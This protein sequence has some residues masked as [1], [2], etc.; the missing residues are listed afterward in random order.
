MCR[1]H[2]I[3]F[4]KKESLVLN[5]YKNTIS[6]SYSKL[7]KV[8]RMAL[9]CSLQKNWYFSQEISNFHSFLLKRYQ[10]CCMEQYLC[11]EIIFPYDYI[12]KIIGTWGIKKWFDLHN[13]SYSLHYLENIANNIKKIST[14]DQ[15]ATIIS[16]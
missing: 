7:F 13:Q 9:V 10:N 6:H 1:A 4:S 15:V 11:N 16:W 3:S 12:I 2:N 5:I 8:S 14:F